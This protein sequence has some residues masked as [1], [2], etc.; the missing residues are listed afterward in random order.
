MDYPACRGRGTGL[1]EACAPFGVGKKSEEVGGIILKTK[2]MIITIQI[3]M[4]IIIK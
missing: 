1:R 2:T 4:I 3:I